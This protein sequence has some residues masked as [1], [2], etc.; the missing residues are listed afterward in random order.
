MIDFFLII[1]ALVDRENGGVAVIDMVV[2]S[3]A[4]PCNAILWYRRIIVAQ[5]PYHL[6]APDVA[7]QSWFSAIQA[8]TQI[9]AVSLEPIG[10]LFTIRFIISSF[11]LTRYRSGMHEH[12]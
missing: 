6:V 11:T 8:S 10:N 5:L 7:D 9:Y 3:V 2:P 4:Q 12:T 1:E